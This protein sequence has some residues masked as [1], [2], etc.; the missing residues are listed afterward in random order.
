MSVSE[1]QS[2]SGAARTALIQDA[3]PAWLARF[4]QRLEALGEWLNPILVKECRQ[5][6]KSRQFLITFSMVLLC[7]WLWSIV[8]L[9][10]LGPGVSYSFDGPEMFYFYYLILAFPLIIIV[11]YGAFR[12]L[13][14]EREDRT[15]ELLSITTLKPRQ[16][17]SG[18][19]ASAV[20]QMLVYFSAISPCLAF[21]YLLRGIDIVTILFVLAY[22][23]LASLALSLVA[24]L[25]ATISRER[26]WQI[27][28]SVIVVVGLAFLFIMALMLGHML[29]RENPFALTEEWFWIGHAAA[30]SAYASTFALLFCAAAAQLTFPSDNRST[31]LRVCMLA[32]HVLFTGWMAYGVSLEMTRSQFAVL[33]AEPLF[34]YLSLAAV[35][36][37]FMGS[38]MTGESPNLSPRVQRE[39]PRSG[40]A[41]ALFTWFNPGPGTGYVFALANVTGAVLFT[42]LVMWIWKEFYGAF[43]GRGLRSFENEVL[44][45]GALVI[46]YFTIYLGLGKLVLAW[47]RR[48][49]VA[50]V[51]TSLVTNVLLVLVGCGV[52]LLIHLMSED[53]RMNTSYRMLHITNPIYTA[54]YTVDRPSLLGSETI[55]V[56]AILTC[57][58]VVV[59]LLNAR[60]IVQETRRTRVALPK[61]VTEEEAGLTALHS[62]LAYTPTNPWDEGA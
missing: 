50:G 7:G 6:L 39:L 26:H 32:Q 30:A 57:G 35:Y 36:W 3:P 48:R 51:L 24:I 47:L 9:A 25:I 46:C 28:L 20:V 4:D 14:G 18:K 15:Y 23:F 54:I 58:A 53:I 40:L 29:L 22:L 56:L 61:R 45:F 33:S 19:L 1:A 60:S 2:K 52:P 38:F 10:L 16:I 13:A 5:A 44:I 55:T 31:P 17:I 8:G 49:N 43:I 11:P 21:T 37:F 62:T 34:I 59:L 27:V 41:R 42:F 12:S